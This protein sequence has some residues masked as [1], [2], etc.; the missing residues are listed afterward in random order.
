M[1]VRE[2]LT[3][4]GNAPMRAQGGEND[5]SDVVRFSPQNKAETMRVERER[6][7]DCTSTDRLQTTVPLIGTQY[8]HLYSL[9]SH[10]RLN[11]IR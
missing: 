9:K 1:V 8:S 4:P 11:R 10:P 2:I 7:V 5:N 6:A 3:I